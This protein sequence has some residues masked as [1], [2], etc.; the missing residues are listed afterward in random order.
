MGFF[1]WSG[2]KVKLNI[3]WLLLQVLHHHCPSHVLQ[4]GQIVGQRPCCWDGIQAS[5]LVACEGFSHFLDST[6]SA[7]LLHLQRVVW[8]L[9]LAMGPT[10]SLQRATHCLSNSLCCLGDFHGTPLANNSIECNSVL[11]LVGNKKWTVET[12]YVHL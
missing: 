1:S 7:Q 12:P 11:L 10:V 6:T 9:F 5:L 8:V 4:T 2:P 3:S